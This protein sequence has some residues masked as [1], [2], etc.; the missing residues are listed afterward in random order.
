ME[1]AVRPCDLQKLG[2]VLGYVARGVYGEVDYLKGIARTAV[3]W[4]HF[5]VAG[6]RGNIAAF[7]PNT[8]EHPRV[9]AI[10]RLIYETSKQR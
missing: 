5:A 6:G 8:N 2:D 4:L 3:G 9:I 1:Y 10:C 7:A